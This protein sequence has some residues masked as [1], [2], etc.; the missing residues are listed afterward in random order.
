MS[1]FH[2]CPNPDPPRPLPP[3]QVWE[4]WSRGFHL[5]HR[6][7]A[8]MLRL[9]FNVMNI[10]GDTVLL[11]DPY[12]WLKTPPLNQFQLLGQVGGCVRAA[13]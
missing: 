9:G 1:L 5:R 4:D 8:R 2:L 6:L 11:H 3:L 10:D 13:S 12:M 7:S